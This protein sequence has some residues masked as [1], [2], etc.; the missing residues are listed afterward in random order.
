MYSNN[1]NIIIII[2]NTTLFSQIF[3]IPIFIEFFSIL[4]KKSNIKNNNINTS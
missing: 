2:K 3:K 1:N 4:S